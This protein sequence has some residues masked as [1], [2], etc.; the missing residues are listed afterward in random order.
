M[1]FTLAHFKPFGPGRP[2]IV[3][4][5]SVAETFTH[6]DFSERSR[7]IMKNWE[8]THKCEDE[9]DAE[10]LRKR[11]SLTAENLTMTN[12]ISKALFN[13]DPEEIDVL[14]DFPPAKT[15]LLFKLSVSSNN[16]PG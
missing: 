11:A 14:K 13:L 12:S 5:S 8:D 1:L 3:P 2:L 6:F 10:R 9:R 16:H 7:M 4:D 15:L